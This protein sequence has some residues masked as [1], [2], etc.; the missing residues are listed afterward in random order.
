MRPVALPDTFSL[1]AVD[2]ARAFSTIAAL[3]K[4]ILHDIKSWIMG[5]TA[6]E[7]VKK[8]PLG[9]WATKATKLGMHPTVVTWVGSRPIS[10]G[11]SYDFHGQKLTAHSLLYD[12]VGKRIPG[13]LSTYLFSLCSF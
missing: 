9:N 11:V 13:R 5:D 6:A 10:D 7:D 1:R 4:L 12:N 3:R 2:L 8:L